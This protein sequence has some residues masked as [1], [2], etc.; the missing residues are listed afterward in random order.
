MSFAMS[1]TNEAVSYSISCHGD[2]SVMLLFDPSYH[3]YEC[4]SAMVYDRK[5][6][7][8]E[9]RGL[10]ELKRLRVCRDNTFTS[11]HSCKPISLFPVVYC[12]SRN[13]LV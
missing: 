10:Q 12:L 4:V 9:G 13:E 5:W 1:N 6:K 3:D 2:A 11:G 7:Q 8:L